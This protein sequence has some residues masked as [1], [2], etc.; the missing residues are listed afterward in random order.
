M[1]DAERMIAIMNFER[2]HLS[3]DHPEYNHAC[4]HR[5]W[6]KQAYLAGYE[7]AKKELADVE[8]KK[9]QSNTSNV[10]E[11]PFEGPTSWI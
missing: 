10:R 1:T 6:E 11:L 8:A 2:W 9:S 7:R 4:E 3:L 5:P